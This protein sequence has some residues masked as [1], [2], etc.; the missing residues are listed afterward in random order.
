MDQ[1]S[2]IN[3]TPWRY[4]TVFY[5]HNG[6][7]QLRNILGVLATAILLSLGAP[8]WFKTLKR[9]LALRD[10]LSPENERES[11]NRKSGDKSDQDESRGPGVT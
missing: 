10:V 11:T 3:V 9:G 8:F 2:L 4:G 7:V 5:L 1:L 6:N